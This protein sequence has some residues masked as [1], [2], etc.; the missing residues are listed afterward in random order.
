ML[1]PMPTFTPQDVFQS[2]FT[3][4]RDQATMQLI[5]SSTMQ[6]AMHANLQKTMER[7]SLLLEQEAELPFQMMQAPPKKLPRKH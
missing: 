4:V 6:H 7:T 2:W 3:A 5:A 1:Y